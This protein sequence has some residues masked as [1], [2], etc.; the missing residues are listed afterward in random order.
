MGRSPLVSEIKAA[1]KKR[2]SGRLSH[3]LTGALGQPWPQGHPEYL[4]AAATALINWD[5]Q[6]L[7][8][9]QH[10]SLC[11][12]HEGQ[13]LETWLEAYLRFRNSLPA[14]AVRCDGNSDALLLRRRLT[15]LIRNLVFEFPVDAD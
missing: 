15:D 12:S 4:L 8:I 6:T 1:L 5:A 11:P 2:D 7:G 9:I 13:N 14:V 3:A 10:P